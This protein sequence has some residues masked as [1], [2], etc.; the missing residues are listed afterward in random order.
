[1]CQDCM[2]VFVVFCCY[3]DVEYV[4]GVMYWDCKGVYGGYYD[5]I[6]GFVEVCIV[7]DCDFDIVFFVFLEFYFCC[8]IGM[9]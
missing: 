2:F 6:N 8:S 1:M 9:G 7:V 4:E 5:V 3:F